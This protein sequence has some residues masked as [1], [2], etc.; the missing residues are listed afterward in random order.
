MAINP[1][2]RMPAGAPMRLVNLTPHMINLI[3][4]AGATILSLDP[5]GPPAR[6]AVAYEPGGMVVLPGGEVVSVRVA[7]FGEPENLPEPERDTIYI[8]SQITA[9]AAPERRDLVFPDD[10]VRDAA[11]NILG[12][13][14]FGQVPAPTGVA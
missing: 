9:A 6:A 5:A 7:A 8:V 12:N 3:D 10:V 11:G 1:D 14:V 2:E 4:V 13:R